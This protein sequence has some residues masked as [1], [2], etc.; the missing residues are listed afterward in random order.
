MQTQRIAAW[1]A[2][3]MA[4]TLLAG[5]RVE[6]DKH[7]DSKDVKI[8]T[9]FGGMQVKTNDSVV[10]ES[11]GIKAYP[12][13]Q[14]VKKD[15]D[16]GA[17]DV[18]MSFGSFQLRVK[19]VSYRTG[20]SPDKVEEFY[21]NDLKRYG[22]VIACRDN[23]T[24]GTPAQTS[25]GLTCDDNSKHHITVQDRPGKGSLE[26]KTGSKQHQ[27]M[28]EIDA[29][30]GGTKFGLVALDLPGKMSGDEDDDTRQ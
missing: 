17:A 1:V 12:G 21:R 9:P 4:T 13:A 19:A 22:D 6:T 15:K 7:G 18:N 27:H 20:D 16:N 30:G 28:V 5:C 25:Q 10:L 23:R 29:D 11:M 2:A 8:S 3:G 24:V 14:L 26:L